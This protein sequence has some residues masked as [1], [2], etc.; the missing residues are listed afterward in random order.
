MFNRSQ[1]TA[2]VLPVFFMV[3]LLASCA[4][5]EETLPA[6]AAQESV[7]NIISQAETAYEEAKRLGHAWTKTNGFLQEA[8]SALAA[9][10]KIEARMAAD[11]ALFTARASVNQANREKDAW[12][13]R[14]LK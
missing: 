2:I 14:V 13:D 10:N 1:P 8:R 7:Q 12:R 4:D 9:G 3:F 6:D 5:S 11:R